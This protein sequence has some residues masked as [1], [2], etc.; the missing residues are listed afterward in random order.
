MDVCLDYVTVQGP[1]L[2]SNILIY[3]IISS[4]CLFYYLVQNRCL[5]LRYSN[6]LTT[7]DA[8]RIHPLKLLLPVVER[9]ARFTQPFSARALEGLT[10]NMPYPL[11]IG[12]DD[13]GGGRR[14][15]SL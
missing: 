12:L 3:R 10:T 4:G 11:Y 1:P 6:Q 9:S 5:R 14:E 8:N 7:V 13:A 15:G 2:V